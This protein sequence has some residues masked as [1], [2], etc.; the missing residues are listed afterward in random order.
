MSRAPLSPT[1]S[2]PGERMVLVGAIAGAHGVRGEVRIKSF[3]AE[4]GAIAG[5]GPVSDE[6]GTQFRL[7]VRGVVR[8]LLIARLDGIADR[9]AA[10]ALKGTRLYVPRSALPR[11][12]RE[13]WYVGDLEGLAAE[14]ANGAALGRV[15]SVEN[16]GAG[17]VLEIARP[18]GTS[19]LLPFTHRT[20]PVVD[21]AGGRIVVDPPAE[22]E[23]KPETAEA[24]P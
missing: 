1:S 21:V 7:K 11:T 23:A 22:T 18:D 17:D 8:G 13:E 9:D 5:Y 12:A 3:T 20:V 24:A 14:T 6:G 2:P 10:E 16:Y 15:K 4:P 19:L